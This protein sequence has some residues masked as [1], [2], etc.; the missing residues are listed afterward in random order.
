MAHLPTFRLDGE[1]A[2]VTGAQSQ[3]M[4]SPHPSALGGATTQTR[5]IRWLRV[6]AA[7]RDPAKPGPYDHCAPLGQVSHRRSLSERC[8][9]HALTWLARLAVGGG[10][11]QLSCR[12]RGTPGCRCQRTVA[13]V[14]DMKYAS[15]GR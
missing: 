15:P 10:Q 3:A 7:L 12:D 13:L 2:V 5:P 9:V 1:T 8:R 11:L 4:R 14:L 6:I